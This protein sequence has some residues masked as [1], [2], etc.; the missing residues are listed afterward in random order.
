L[1]IKA[2][3]LLNAAKWVEGEHGRE[4]LRDVLQA[5]SPAV[6]ERYT[7][8]IPIDWHP[9]EELVDF[10]RAAE[11]VLS[12]GR[13]SGRVAEAIGAAGARANMKGITVR[14]AVWMARPEQLVARAAGVWRQFNDEGSMDL[15][16]VGENLGRFE[17]KGVKLEDALFC[18]VLTGWFREIAA[19]VGAIS[20]L[21]RHIEC[22]ARGGARCVWE[23]RYARVELKGGPPRE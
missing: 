1:R 12:A 8:V 15:I 6:R 20:P 23:V 13:A 11:R 21:A 16:E 22:K 4:G 10:V 18:A 17:L 5:C 7:S 19:G 14:I 9:V 2:Q 3:G